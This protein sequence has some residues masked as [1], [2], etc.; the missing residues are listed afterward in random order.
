MNPKDIINNFLTVVTKKYFCFE[1]RAGRKEFWMY[2]IA[3]IIGS[4]ILNLIP[5]IGKILSG[6][7]VL[8]LLCPSLGITA[9]RLHDIG[10]SGWLQLLVLVPVIGAIAL[11]VICIKAGDGAAN[12]YGEAVAE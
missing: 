12:K 10:K 9:R 11:L 7:W 3:Y 8:A 1:G 6:V 4:I 5:G 2:I